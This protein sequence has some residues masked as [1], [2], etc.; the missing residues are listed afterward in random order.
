M[1]GQGQPGAGPD[2]GGA[3]GGEQPGP[4]AQPPSGDDVVEGEFKET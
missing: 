4:G 1:Y 2:M 3:P